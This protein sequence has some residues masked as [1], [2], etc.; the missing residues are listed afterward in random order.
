MKIY[1]THAKRSAV[2]SFLGSLKD[3]SPGKL[4]GLV[5]QDIVKNIDK[6]IIDEVIV[7][8]VLSAGQGQ[9][10]GRQASVNG[11]LPYS[12]VA[13][14]LNMLCGSGMK[15]VMNGISQIKSRSMDVVLAGGVESM[16]QSPYLVPCSSRTGTKLGD[17]KLVD[18]M[19]K[20]GLLDYFNDYH[21]GV[22]AENIASKYNIHRITQD[23]FAV[24]S[25]KKAIEANLNGKF[26]NEIVSIEIKAKKEKKY[27]VKMNT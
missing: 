22:T 17:L 15:A 9:G 18:S 6:N 14:S 16:S 1:I 4:A 7:G 11:T 5:I 21:M 12:T 24:N 2:G 10:I 25:Q 19:I 13:Y 27:F 3:I 20:D 23:K 8:N 26:K